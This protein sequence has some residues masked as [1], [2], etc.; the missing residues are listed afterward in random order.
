MSQP[1]LASAL[2]LALV[3][4]ACETGGR[5]P[6]SG[7]AA[8]AATAAPVPL[9]DQ[10]RALS[11]ESR[12]GPK[13]AAIGPLAGTWDVV[14]SDVGAD[15]K[16]TERFRGTAT[17]AWILGGRFLKWDVAVDFGGVPGTTTGFL[18]FDARL[19]EY[20]LLMISDLAQG[21]AVAHGTGELAA[22]GLVFTVEQLDPRSGARARSRSRLRL[23]AGDH[24]ILQ[25]LEPDSPAAGSGGGEHATRVWHYRRAHAAAR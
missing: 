8:A 1:T 11:T 21:M 23:L 13:H 15:Q 10:V 2:L 18:G 20:E 16:E 19:D 5:P 12:P 4:A 17:L 24:F 6:S 22:Q 25:Q 9:E 3:L 14:L 7:A